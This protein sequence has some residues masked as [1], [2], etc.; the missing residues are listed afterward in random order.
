LLPLPLERPRLL[1]DTI[2]FTSTT[3][4]VVRMDRMEKI[5]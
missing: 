1:S 5:I 2:D 4:K 3:E